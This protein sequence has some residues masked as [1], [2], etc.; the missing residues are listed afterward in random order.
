MESAVGGARFPTGRASFDPRPDQAT[1]LWGHVAEL[2]AGERDHATARAVTTPVDPE[3]LRSI[4][5]S[6]DFERPADADGLIEE[7]AALLREYTVH[8]TNPRYFGPLNP[9]PTMLGVVG[10]TP[11]AAFNPQLA[12]WSHAPAAVEIEAHLLRFLG[13]RLG[14]P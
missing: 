12:A 9:T 11:A 8:T 2:L 10:D 13:E 5:G 4:I 6:Y 14:Y 7:V 3:R 1:R